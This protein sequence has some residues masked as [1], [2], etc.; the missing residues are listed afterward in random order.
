M[1]AATIVDGHLEWRARPDP[2][3]GPGQLLVRVEAAGVNAADL[4]Q[5]QGF[6]PAPPDAPPDIPGL[7]LAGEVISA[8][9]A[10]SRFAG[11]D[12]V[13]ALVGG[14]GQAEL[15]VVDEHHAMAL[16]DGI[17]WAEGAGF[18]EVFCTAHDALFTQCG[19][20]LG[21]RV[22]IT[23]AAGGVGTAAVQL[24]AAAGAE[25]VASVWRPEH[26]DAVAALGA[27][28]VVDPTEAG[29]QGPFDAVLEL[30]SGEGFTDSLGALGT[31]GRLCVIGVGG[32]A[33][34]PLEL[35][36]LMSRR[37]VICG[38]TLRA[39][40]A[41]EKTSVVRFV[42]T[43]VLPL[44]SSR[45]VR[46]PLFRTFPL[47]EAAGAYERFAAGGKLGKIVLRRGG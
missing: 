35:F 13:M 41:A 34:V 43:K 11:G 26:R 18:P 36:T 38:S 17:D 8:G 12:R 16:P 46:V 37:L 1:Q 27:S 32:G 25:V 19:L 33:Q 45:R 15:A 5:V 9:R 2:V 24:A 40:S 14:G 28:R 42:E 22:L 6:Y 39:R 4:A 47:A 44:F 29:A 20:G 3:P 23:G 21:D 30:V 31:G 10:V 7:E